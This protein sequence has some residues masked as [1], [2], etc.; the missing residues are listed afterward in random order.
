MNAAEKPMSKRAQAKARAEAKRAT[1]LQES[2]DLE[3]ARET[4]RA[5][6]NKMPESFGEWGVMRTRAYAK[7]MEILRYRA[8]LGTIKSRELRAYIGEI[9]RIET[10]DVDLCA[11][12]LDSEIDARTKLFHRDGSA[13]QG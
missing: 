10:C 7:M 9:Q 6:S 3:Q 13:V 4:A 1:K 12:L 5:M 2:R 11:R 8:E